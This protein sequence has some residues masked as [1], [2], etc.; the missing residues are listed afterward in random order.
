MLA[1]TLLTPLF[2]ANSK[3]STEADRRK[4]DYIFLEAKR[5]SLLDRLDAYFELLDYAHKTNSDDRTIAAEVAPYYIQFDSTAALYG[6]GLIKQYVDE[7]PDDLYK[8]FFFATIA[9][10]FGFPDHALATMRSL[11]R[12]FPD[13][14][15]ITL[16]LAEML[17][18]TKDSVNSMHAIEL[19]DS[20]LVAG[21]DPFDI[22]GRKAQI[23]YMAGDTASIVRTARGLLETSPN[24]PDYN[25]YVGQVYQT[26]LN[27]D[28]ALTFYNRALEIE[29][30]N[31]MAYY[32]KANFYNQR[33]DSV[34]YDRETFD[35][36]RQPDLDVDMKLT[37]LRD[38]VS[39][40]YTDTM[41]QPRI[42]QLF[43]TLVEQ[44]PHESSVHDLYSEYLA[45]IKN[46]EQSA[47][48][49]SLSLDLEPGDVSKWLRLGSIYFTVADHDKAI[50]AARRGLHYFPD[51]IPLFELEANAMLIKGDYS[52]AIA[53]ADSGLAVVDSLD[54]QSLVA[55]MSLKADGLYK[56]G[57][58]EEAVDML[59]RCVE[60]DPDDPG[61]LNNAAYY[62]ACEGRD[63]QRALRMIERSTAM[64]PDNATSLDTYAW[65]LFKL[66]RYDEA[67]TIID[68][69]IELSA[70]DPGSDN[71]GDALSEEVLEHAGDIYFMSGEPE[72]AVDFWTDA[73]KKDPDNELLKRKVAH[74]TYFYK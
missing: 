36:L 29:P 39:R 69:V 41:Q 3:T 61:L 5:Q 57:Q 8:G 73:L 66:K 14:E 48:E 62:M 6:Y 4:A 74:K 24:N 63:L 2:I 15:I 56:L 67:K 22:V 31:G 38:Y 40:L 25:V 43:A 13:R 68:R 44:H 30:S 27:S 18:A 52:D 11:H 1:T 10:R 59:E 16:R 7:N 17:Q 46:Y 60:M 37:L 51:E 32:A 71:A 28:S 58:K 33:N 72:S 19:Y 21:A 55:L 12:N 53:V 45:V 42:S 34:A 54:T 64:T 49:T 70:S 20:L 65:V 26:F 23:Y 50:E 9:S 47:E 35:A